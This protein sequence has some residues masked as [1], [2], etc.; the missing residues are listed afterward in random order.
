MFDNI[1]DI[2]LNCLKYSHAIL[3]RDFWPKP[4]YVN[5]VFDDKIRVIMVNDDVDQV[6]YYP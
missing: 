1:V 2:V 3:D 6:D 4:V 5:V